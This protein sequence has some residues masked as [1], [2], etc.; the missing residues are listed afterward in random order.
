MNR[1]T[2]WAAGL[3]LLAALM[4]APAEAKVTGPCTGMINGQAIGSERITVPQNGTVDYSFTASSPPR[5][6]SVNLYYGGAKV[7]VD[8]AS[9]DSDTMTAS[10][11][12]NVTDYAWLGV[13]VYKLVG[14]VNLASG[15]K[16]TGDVLIVVKGNPLT[17]LMGG[18]GAAAVLAG[19]GGAAAASVA[20]AKAALAGIKP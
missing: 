8:Q 14:T 11:V 10:G 13:G 7:L 16:C 2:W 15:E 5:S 18:V 4:A 20:A 12:A 3:L 19:T 1:A 17:T 9:S 6:W